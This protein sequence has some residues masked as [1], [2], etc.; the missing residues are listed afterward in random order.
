MNLVLTKNTTLLLVLFFS[1]T[2]SAQWSLSIKS[3][4]ELR[5]FKLTNK[6]EVIEQGLTGATISL[7]AGSKIIS[8]VQSDGGGD[9]EIFAPA[10]GEYILTVSYANS[11]TKKFQVNTFNVP[12]N[13]VRD[14]YKPAF[15]IE[16]VVMAKPFKAIDYSVLQQTLVKINYHDK[17]KRFDD[18]Q[19]YTTQMLNQ[20]GVYRQAETVLIEQFTS[21]NAKGDEALKKGD[22][23]LAKMLYE[24]AMTIIPGEF[25]PV[26][27]LE[28]VGKCLK[29][30]EEKNKETADKAKADADKL[31]NDKLIAEQAAKAKAEQEQLAKQQLEKA[32]A[33]KAKA[34]ADKLAS[35]KLLAEQATKAKTEQEQLAKQQLEKEKTDKAKA[36]ADKLANDKLIAEQAAKTKAEQEQLTKQQ[37]EKEKTDK[38]KADAD[39]LASDKLL[40]EQATKAKTE[41]EQ[42]AKQQ[43]E[44][45]KTDK[46]KADADKLASDKLL[47]EQATKAKTE[48]EQLAKQQLEKEKADK[49][50]TAK[51]KTEQEQLAKQQLEKAKADKAKA[52]ADKLASDKLLAEQA[53]KAKTEQEQL[54]KQQL[55]NEKIIETKIIPIAND[56]NNE[57]GNVKK[58]DSKY[59]IPQAMGADKYKAAL[60]RADELFK[61]KRY[62]EAKPLYEEYLK[63]KPNDVYSVN[64]L[65]EIETL[66]IKK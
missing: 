11:P 32:K 27:Q 33:D 9:F 35:D 14:N 54:A 23:P 29:D 37:L 20:I 48:Q 36:D 62:S 21:T 43:L 57:T 7:Y 5:T 8:Q 30:A 2:I 1:L 51:A 45:E 38:A 65:T 59:S 6:A 39:K 40:A 53:A 25:Y 28:L 64:R 56:N 3:R 17:G 12:E 58:G 50:K 63:Y 31:A 4:V 34:D 19:E 52:D 66:I 18:E 55:E 60:K 16:G 61:M 46:A 49:A 42:L 22:C 24:K 15:A 47:A 10:N 26:Q 44:K 41:Q 13:I